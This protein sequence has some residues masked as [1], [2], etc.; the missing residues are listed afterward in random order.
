MNKSIKFTATFLDEISTDIPH[1]NWGLK[2]WDRDFEAMKAVGIDTVVMIRCGLE[3]FLTY[4]SEVLMK[5]REA[6]RPPV[7]LMEMFLSLAEK[8]KM[9]FLP[10]TYVG[11]RDW[12]NEAIDYEKETDLDCRVAEEIWE[13]YGKHSSAFAGWYL[14]K[15]VACM[16]ENIVGEFVRLGQ[17]CKKISGNLPILI[18]PGM[19][20]R[21]AYLPTQPEYKLG[22]DF[23]RHEHDWGQIFSMIRGAVDIVAFQD[24]HCD[25]DELPRALA[26]NRRLADKHGLELW[27]NTESFDRDMPF[28]F[29]PIKWEKMRLKLEF[30]RQAGIDKAITFEFSHFMSPNSFWATAGHLYNRYREYL[31]EEGLLP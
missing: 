22:M 1:Q 24:G 31:R 8:H 9:K 15:E 12:G 25:I 4:P 20:G 19:L 21:R 28:R 27:T 6:F 7:D 3:R 26:I 13:K 11:Q 10:G 17:F 29:P 18:S 2:E 16:K 5:E 30:A 23:E 14:A